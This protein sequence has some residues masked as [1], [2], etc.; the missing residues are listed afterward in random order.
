MSTR[1][2]SSGFERTSELAYRSNDAFAQKFLLPS[3]LEVK[4]AHASMAKSVDV[5]FLYLCVTT[6]DDALECSALAKRPCRK[7]ED[8][9]MDNAET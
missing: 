2:L 5:V 3:D 6:G 9:G 4:L 7:A 8:G 1:D